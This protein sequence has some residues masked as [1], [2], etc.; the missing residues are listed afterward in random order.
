MKAVLRSLKVVRN[1]FMARAN[2]V[3]IPRSQVNKYGDCDVLSPPFWASLQSS[4]EKL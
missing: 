2:W 1:S 3:L 4:W